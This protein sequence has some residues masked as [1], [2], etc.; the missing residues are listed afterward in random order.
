MSD[1]PRQNGWM[2]IPPPLLFAL[3]LILG[4]VLH[5][6][7]PLAHVSAEIAGALEW[8]GIALI[9][10]GVGHTLSS[11]ALFVRS[12]TTLIPHHRASVLVTQGA[13]RWTRN[14]MYV[15]LTLVYF[16]IAVLIVALW[17][18]LFLPLVLIVMDRRVIPTE[19]RQLGELFG[20]SYSAYV[21]RVRRWL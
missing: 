7:Y 4:V 13:Y 8:L 21:G 17:P 20:P 18:L 1:S 12:R 5:N 10:I 9:V 16:G 15:G 3:P 19:E 6:R 11:V 2:W 14:P